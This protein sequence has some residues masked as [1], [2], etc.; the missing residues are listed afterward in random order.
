MK[1]IILL[2]FILSISLSVFSQKI[3]TLPTQ[4]EA[5]TKALVN[6]LNETKRT[7]L[8]DLTKSF[9]GNIKKGLY[10]DNF[11]SDLATITNKMILI[12]GKVHPQVSGVLKSFME[13]NT[14]NLDPTK[15]DEWLGVLDQTMTHAKK[16]DTKTTLKFLDFAYAL[17][18]NNYFF[19]GK[20]KTWLFKADKFKLRHTE[21][22]PI[23]ELGLSKIV[24][25]CKSKGDG[26]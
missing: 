6:L 4:K 25:Y 8:K 2:T 22:G 12:R 15:W 10:T 18:K 21:N 13:M 16:G 24:T 19:E 26:K 7:E 11:Y 23:V 9:N 1:K 14:L 20:A 3:D 5:F 17:Y